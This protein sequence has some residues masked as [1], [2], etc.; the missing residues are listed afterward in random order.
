[1]RQRGFTLIELLIVVSLIVVAS[2]VATLAVRD[3][4]A[5]QLER[6][7]SRLA[8]LLESAR[9]EA[10]AAGVPVLWQTTPN[11][12]TRDFEFVGLPP[13]LEL[14]NRWLDRDVEAEIRSEV[15]L[16]R[17]ANL[18]PEPII[19]AQRIELKLGDQRLSLSTDGLGPFGLGEIPRR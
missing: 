7:A 19:G 3:P 1:M 15:G 12:S 13:T 2:A 6:E 9:A 17:A 16:Q 8:A 10:R 14:P 5:T 18:G 11:D 4:A